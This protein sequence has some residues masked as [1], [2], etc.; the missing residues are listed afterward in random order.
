[1]AR[2]DAAVA[3]RTLEA[4]LVSH[5]FKWILYADRSAEKLAFAQGIV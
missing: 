4:G 5:C 1:M 3:K 2:G